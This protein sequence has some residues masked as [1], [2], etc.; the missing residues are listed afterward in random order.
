MLFVQRKG[1]AFFFLLLIFASVSGSDGPAPGVEQDLARQRAKDYRDL[2]YRLRVRV[3][4]EKSEPM[5]AEL[6]ISLE[7]RSAARDLVL[8]FTPSRAVSSVTYN[9]TEAPWSCQ[10]EHIVIAAAALKTG[11]A[12]LR[13]SFRLGTLSLNRRED[14]LYTLFVP[15]RARTAF[16]CFDQPDM[17]GT[18]AVELDLPAGWEGVANGPLQSVRKT[19][20]GR[21]LFRFRPSHPLPTYLMAFVAG[22]LQRLEEMRKGRRVQIFHQERDR[23]MLER[24]APELF[25][26]VFHALAWMEEYTRTAYPFDKYDLI[27]VPS[28]QYNGMEHCGATLYRASSLLLDEN[29]T[30]E[31]KLARAGLIAHET[32]HMWFGDLVTMPWFDEVWLKEVFAGFMA[33]KMVRDFSFTVDHR[34]QFTL[35]HVPYALSVDRSAGTHPITRPLENLADAGTLYGHL[36]YHKAPIVM[37]QL[38]MRVGPEPLRRALGEYLKRNAYGNAGWDDLVA[39]LAQNDPELK[40]WSRGWIYESGLPLIAVRRE[41]H[42]VTLIQ[43]RG[44][45]PERCWRQRLGLVVQKGERAR[46]VHVEMDR[47]VHVLDLPEGF[48]EPDV[49]LPAGDGRGYGIFLLDGLSCRNL[50]EDPMRLSNPLWRGAAWLALW[51]GTVQHHVRAESLLRTAMD[52]VESEEDHQVLERI[53]ADLP[54][55]VW[56]LLP[57]ERRDGLSAECG[58]RLWEEMMRRSPE[59]RL[60]FFNACAA[61]HPGEA[62][63]GRIVD[64]L[65][66]KERVDGVNLTEQR[67]LELLQRLAVYP[68]PRLAALLDSFSEKWKSP[69]RRGQLAFLR[70]LFSSRKEEWIA[71]FRELCSN[72]EKRER[73]P[74]VLNALSLIHHPLRSEQTRVLIP[75]M[76][77]KLPEIQRSGD[78][79]F[80]AGWVGRSLWGHRS[81]QAAAMV[82][83]FL[84]KDNAVSENLRLMV[85]Q[86][87]D[88]LLREN[89]I[90]I[91]QARERVKGLTTLPEP[92]NAANPEMLDRAADTIEKQFREQGWEVRKQTVAYPGGST[93]NISVL[94]GDEM[95]PRLV[96]GAHYDVCGDTPGADD[97]ASG[98]A[99]LLETAELLS[100]VPALPGRAV[101][102]VAYTLEEPPYFGTRLMGSRSHSQILKSKGIDLVMMLSVDMVG[103]YADENSFLGVIGREEDKKILHDMAS[104]LAEEPILQARPLPLSASARGL[105]WSDHRNYWGDGF[106]AAMLHSC[107]F[108]QNP[109]Y[110]RPGDVP[111][112]LDY[113]RLSAVSRALY[114]LAMAWPFPSGKQDESCAHLL[115]KRVNRYYHG[116]QE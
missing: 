13:I 32:A 10:N 40:D 98:V 102:L 35:E 17:K 85:L 82:R 63:L 99:V 25:D 59:K 112:L 72:P 106:P 38:E 60:A 5:P 7:I 66:G 93:R 96:L 34:L 53:L 45:G 14:L 33:D 8:D 2:H 116:K 31:Q 83:T 43:G 61:I 58:R 9:G 4:E 3:P 48:Q 89:D 16:P 50:L 56:R 87:A 41:N 44:A 26:Q 108:F 78:I 101:E 111:E 30:L 114:R 100:R 67:E 97:N 90:E 52:W 76:L 18:F 6:L 95:D 70:P 47:K 57:L 29:A 22:R 107:P 79:F 20:N 84:S 19:D 74:W 115:K 68:I 51:E 91:M 64:L 92:R 109:N 28:F 86:G 80:P 55:L 42:G 103:Y 105:D 75:E 11:K 23:A 110:H 21:R 81:P 49:V 15:D 24:N 113:P 36:I 77:V 1:L 71:F 69:D 37:D 39:I 46:L 73:E 65:R 88:F 94:W 62:T 54:G 12:L 104:V 27:L